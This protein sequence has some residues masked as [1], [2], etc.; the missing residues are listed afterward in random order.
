MVDIWMQIEDLKK[1]SLKKDSKVILSIFWD[2]S[3]S[4][5]DISGLLLLQ[6]FLSCFLIS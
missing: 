1:F 5:N 2:P 3:V 4:P 6:N